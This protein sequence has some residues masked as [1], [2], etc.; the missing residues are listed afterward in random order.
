MFMTNRRFPIAHRQILSF[1]PLCM[2]AV[3]SAASAGFT[4]TSAEGEMPSAKVVRTVGLLPL[5]VI[6]FEDQAVTGVKPKPRDTWSSAA[7]EA[8]SAAFIAEMEAKQISLVVISKEEIGP[9][10]L[11]N[12]YDVPDRLMHT[13]APPYPESLLSAG[14]PPERVREVMER[15]HLDAVWVLTGINIIEAFGPPVHDAPGTVTQG[16]EGMQLL[17]RAA[18]I[19]RNGTVLFSDMI[20]GDAIVK[21]EPSGRP[22]EQNSTTVD[23]RDPAVARHCAK[24]LLAEYRTEQEKVTAAQTSSRLVAEKAALPKYPHPAEVRLGLGIFFVAPDGVDL[25]V[26]FIPPDSHWQFGYRYVRWTDTFDDPYTGRGLTRTTEDMQGPF[27]NYLFHPE[28]NGTW[29]LGVSL[30]RWSR[31]E[32]SLVTDASSSDSVVAPFYGGGYTGHMGRH[33]YYNAGIFLSP[34]TELKTNTG[35]SS[36]E[37]S[38]G[39]DIQLQIGIVF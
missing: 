10:D 15:H 2:L 29:Y 39:F 6:L 23:L 36:E 16:R 22:A 4:A 32:V 28:E 5:M 30:L 37:S 7:A 38:G 21:A 18:L 31:T 35:V 1:F 24:A 9:G 17:F 12:L 26:S 11:S 33:A 3:F 8:V 27:V 25:T 20:D 14:Y 34:G 19:E 13:T